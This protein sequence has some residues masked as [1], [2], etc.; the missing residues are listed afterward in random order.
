[1]SLPTSTPSPPEPVF[2]ERLVQLFGY[3]FR[4]NDRINRRVE[5]LKKKV[6]SMSLP[7]STP[8]PPEPVVLECLVKVLAT[9]PGLM[10]GLIE[11]W[12]I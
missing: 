9:S 8:S 4:L 7:T 5:D 1:M 12:K 3:K 6:L 11:G 10:I 2:L